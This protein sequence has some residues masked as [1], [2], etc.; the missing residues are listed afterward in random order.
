MTAVG[1]YVVYV[2]RTDAYVHALYAKRASKGLRLH[3]I[4]S[5]VRVR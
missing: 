3:G 1:V 5:G 2:V 4:S